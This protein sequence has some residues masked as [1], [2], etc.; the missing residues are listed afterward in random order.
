MS[1]ASSPEFTR[2]R[3]GHVPALDGIRGLAVLAVIAHHL[4]HLRGGYLGVDAFFVL[5]GFLITGLLVD[6]VRFGSGGSGSGGGRIDLGRFWTR[7]VKRL[8]PAL[9]LVV[10]VVVLVESFILSDPRAS[11]RREVLSAL[12]YVYNWNAL[13]DNIDYWSSFA[14]PSPLQH[15]WSLAI[16]EQ[17]Y[18]VWP[19]VVVAVIW[20]VRRRASGRA[21]NGRP[22][23]VAWI[24]RSVVA[25]GVTAAVL[26]VTSVVI[27]QIVHD[28]ENLLRVYYGTDTRIAAILFG[29][30]AAVVIRLRPPLSVRGQRIAGF[31]GLALLVPLAVAWVALDGTSAVLYRG[32]LVATGIGVTLVVTAC[33]VAPSSLLNRAMSIAPLRW[34]GLVSY[35][36]YLWHWPIIVWVDQ[37]RTG[38]DGLGLLA[39]RIALTLG[40]T[41]ASYVFVEQPVRTSSI[42][43]SRSAGFALATLVALIA[44]TV[45]VVPVGRD[46]Q[47]SAGTRSTVP[48]PPPPTTADDAVDVATSAPGSI[49]TTPRPLERLMVVG[50]SGAYFLG[51]SLVES[52][53]DGTIVLPR[54]VVGCGI[55]D[56]GGGAWTDDGTFLPDPPGCENWPT[57]WAS[58]VA[59]FEPDHVLLVLS[60]PGIGDREID[61]VR[62]HPCEPEFDEMYAER[63]SL[64]VETAGATGAD[65]V[66]ATAPY[67][68]GAGSDTLPQDR[69]DCLNRVMTS[70]ALA[71][72]GAVLELAEWT[73]PDGECRL[74]V[75]GETLRPDGLHFDGAGGQIAADWILEQLRSG[76]LTTGTD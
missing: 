5:S 36:L 1:A 50:D 57:D 32:G 43:K 62:R 27:A 20:W 34:A 19:L 6:E 66:V 69:I 75:N 71:N 11:L 24:D 47:P 25:I 9:A 53:G 72:G 14:S 33:V 13:A 16:E 61:G 76:A 55:A 28:P 54:G 51:E 46:D 65:V 68:V 45:V 4:G 60:W 10:V 22:D 26:A 74:S 37:E 17:F 29:A 48:I 31:V 12:L 39:L 3:M 35:G 67:Y 7:R 41:I 21:P 38:L 73:C 58:D 52:S 18:L 2:E 15:M 56:I 59:A 8:F 49:G 30:V 42:G 23:G 44:F 64:A 70:T 40:I 63:V